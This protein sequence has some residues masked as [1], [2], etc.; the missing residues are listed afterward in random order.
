[1]K[2]NETGMINMQMDRIGK[3]GAAPEMDS[4]SKEFQNQIT[5]A[6][7]RL[8]ELS[9]N[10]DM[11]EEEKKQKRQEIQ[12]QITELNNQLRQHQIE[13]RREQQAQ[14]KSEGDMPDGTQEEEEKQAAG[15]PQNGMKA[16]VSAESAIKQAKAQGRVAM[17][18]EN[19]VR[20]L[21][22]EIKQDAGRGRDTETKQ[23]ELENLEIRATNI[24]GA[25][26]GILS[27]AAREIKQVT[28][29]ESGEDKKKAEEQKKLS[30]KTVNVA[31]GAVSK[32]KTDIYTRGKMFSSVDIH[33]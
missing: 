12:K 4:E 1:M 21:Q 33:I 19:K 17:E 5:N 10:N 22:G 11:T 30:E 7:N 3:A 8:Q 15:L 24:S 27:D 2:V 23:R 28:E 20:V 29:L 6:Q 25:Q 32:N 9:A 18:M 13:L 31:M 26:M 14:K 16:V